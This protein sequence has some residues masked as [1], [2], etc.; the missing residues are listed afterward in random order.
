MITRNSEVVAGNGA[1]RISI[2]L[3]EISER[4]R[5]A[6]GYTSTLE[7]TGHHPG[8]YEYTVSNRAMTSNVTGSFGVEGKYPHHH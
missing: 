6:A 2:G 5:L 3:T 7:V 1:Y 4:N 8:V